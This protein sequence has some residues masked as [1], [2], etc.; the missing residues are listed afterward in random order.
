MEIKTEL[1]EI[2]KDISLETNKL[3][4]A[5]IRFLAEVKF[6]TLMLYCLSASIIL[7]FSVILFLFFH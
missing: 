5:T 2:Y 1:L 3:L 6:K 7:L 4:K